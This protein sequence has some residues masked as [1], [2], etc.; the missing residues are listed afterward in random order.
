MP[1]FDELKGKKS[2]RQVTELF[3]RETD[4]IFKVVFSTGEKLETTWNHPFWIMENHDK[5]ERG[6]PAVSASLFHGTA[7]PNR[8][9]PKGKWVAAKDLKPGQKA[10]TVSGRTVTV[11]D[12]S[13]E[14]RSEKV[15]NF[16]VQENHT[17]YVGQNGV[18]VHNEAGAYMDT[19]SRQV[20]N[21]IGEEDEKRRREQGPFLSNT[22]K[23]PETNWADFVHGKSS[24][25]D[26]TTD[27]FTGKTAVINGELWYEKQGHPPMIDTEPYLT[28]IDA[29]KGDNGKQ[30]K[31]EKIMRGNGDSEY[32][33]WNGSGR[34]GR[35]SGAY[36]PDSEGNQLAYHRTVSKGKQK[37]VG[38]NGLF[39]SGF[40][41]E[42]DYEPGTN[43]RKSDNYSAGTDGKPPTLTVK[44]YRNM[45]DKGI[46]ENWIMGEYQR[47]SM[48]SNAGSDTHFRISSQEGSPV[49][50]NT[51]GNYPPA[52]IE[53]IND[54]VH[55]LP[56][57]NYEELINTDGAHYESPHY[58]IDAASRTPDFFS[59]KAGRVIMPKND[60]LLYNP[61]IVEFADG[62]SQKTYHGSGNASYIFEG[63]VLKAGEYIGRIGAMPNLPTHIHQEYRNSSGDTMDTN[64]IVS[65]FMPND[66]RCRN[67][68]CKNPTIIEE[69]KK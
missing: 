41:G 64:Q 37:L 7:S 31:L 34:K 2:Y 62:S 42:S 56:G 60:N 14:R 26:E 35:I 45:S 47:T 15:Y 3:V 30:Y 22:V 38:E 63:Q 24:L 21:R 68:Y 16:A 29:V 36:D 1:S 51:S 69:K 5:L 33:I 32:F 43:K 4:L 9:K 46:G 10:L 11:T 17:Y 48:S 25:T 8:K 49:E 58:G 18:L 28:R 59:S 23:A 67:N 61:I 19:R 54:P 39:T 13:Q 40:I 55:L 66:F 53:T 27:L 12:V 44:A 52:H 20:Y 65:Q 57:K 50:R 6:P